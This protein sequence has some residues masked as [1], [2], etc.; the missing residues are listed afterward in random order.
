[1][2]YNSSSKKDF[3]V[4][5]GDKWWIKYLFKVDPILIKKI[6]VFSLTMA[7]IL[8][9]TN[10]WRVFSP[11]VDPEDVLL[12]TVLLEDGLE[13]LLETIDRGL[14][15]AE[16][17]EARKLRKSLMR[18]LSNMIERTALP[19]R[20]HATFSTSQLLEQDQFVRKTSDFLL[21]PTNFSNTKCLPFWSWE[22]HR[23]WGRPLP[24]CRCPRRHLS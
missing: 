21:I 11:K 3:S 1:M 2:F 9:T 19:E 12:V 8:H 16:N 22:P 20:N 6:A 7:M 18:I 13:A 17:G 15:C 14:A 5:E 4:F 23:S 10:G 24:V